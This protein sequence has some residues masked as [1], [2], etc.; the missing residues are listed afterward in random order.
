VLEVSVRIEGEN[1]SATMK[2]SVRTFM[3][4]SFLKVRDLRLI[5]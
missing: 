3:E 4:L 2:M 1:S 5:V